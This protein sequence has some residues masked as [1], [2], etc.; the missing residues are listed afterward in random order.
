MALDEP[1]CENMAPRR[2]GPSAGAGTGASDSAHVAADL[3]RLLK[4]DVEFDPHTFITGMGGPSVIPA[5]WPLVKAYIADTALVT[6]SETADAL[7]MLVDRHHIVV[8]GAGAATLA[9]ALAGRYDGPTV[10]ILSGGHLD[11]DQLITILKGGAP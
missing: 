8:E 2:G 5:M 9:A 6:L 1:V 3:H 4:V 11:F 7:R 10:C